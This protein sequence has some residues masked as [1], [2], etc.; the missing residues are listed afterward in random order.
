M[1]VCAIDRVAAVPSSVLARFAQRW[2]FHLTDPLDAVGLGVAAGRCPRIDTWANLRY[3]DRS[4]GPVDGRSTTAFLARRRRGSCD[5]RMLPGVLHASSSACR[6]V[7]RRLVAADRAAVRRR[8]RLQSRRPRRRACV[9]HRAA[10]IGTKYGAAA[11]RSGLGRGESRTVGGA[12]L[13]RAAPARRR[14]STSLTRRDHRR[15]TTRRPSADR[16]RRRRTRR[17][18]RWRTCHAGRIAPTGLMIV[19]TGKPDRFARA[20]ATGPV[21]C[22]AAGSASSCRIE[23]SRR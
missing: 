7:R 12:S 3:L 17:R 1:M 9:D 4:R 23:R 8:S 14:A 22:V 15:H 10:A 13:R 18:R 21:S 6:A 2:V 19:A 20:T 5:R 11:N 16:C